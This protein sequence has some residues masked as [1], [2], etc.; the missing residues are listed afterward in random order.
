MATDKVRAAARRLTRL[1]R[2]FR[3]YFGRREAQEHSVVYLRGLM[4]AEGRKN[5]ESIALQF[6]DGRQGGAAGQNEVLSLQGFLSDSPWSAQDVQREIQAMF[7]EELA[8]SA[9]Q[10]PIGVVGVL[11]GS[12]FVKRGSESVGVKRQWCG[13]L[14]KTENCQVGEFLLG[15]TPAG[16]A[17]LDQQ[18]YLPKEWTQNKKRRK[19]AHVPHQIQYQSQTQ[20]AAGLLS[21]T[22][23]NQCVRFD[24]IVV[25]A[26]YGDNGDFLDELEACQQQYLAETRAETTFWTVDPRSQVPAYGGRGRRPSQACRASVRSTQ[27]IA[28]Q[29]RAEDWHALKLRDGEK[30][31]LVFEFARVRVW[32]VR[33]RKPGPPVWLMF[34]R[35][36]EKNPEIK[37]YVSNADEHTPL[38]S[39]ALVSGQRHRVEEYFEEAKGELGMADYEARGWPSWHHHMSLVALAHLFVTLT[40]LDLKQDFPE[41]TLPMAMR[42]LK[43]S[44]SRPE[45]TENDALRITKY[46]LKRNAT[47]RK[48][49]RKS[50]LRKH[51]K[52]K[53]KVLL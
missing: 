41:L 4:L 12:S 53:P 48:S 14:G 5:V 36:L 13:R 2:R 24:W 8:P 35:S 33:N 52:V 21:R 47:A 9:A 10:W 45:L 25:D 1:H 39:M 31:P 22:R 27:A 26:Q 11:D 3:R 23:E 7:V 6:A 49:H 18:L 17:C 20:I 28:Q 40:K 29:L 43:S 15:V 44:L 32:S 46:H 34:R 16:C 37:Y 50:W 38:E 19:K 30:G 51:K 42:L